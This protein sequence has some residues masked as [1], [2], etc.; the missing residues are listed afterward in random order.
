MRCMYPRGST[1]GLEW[2]VG[3]HKYS[4]LPSCLSLSFL[5]F[6]LFLFCIESPLELIELIDNSSIRYGSIAP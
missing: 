5:Y 4:C 6:F 1:A 2:T 3:M